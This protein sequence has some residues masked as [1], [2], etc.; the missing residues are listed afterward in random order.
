MWKIYGTARQAT[1]DNIIQ[2]M[3]F[4]CWTTKATNTHSD[5]ITLIAF[6]RQQWLRERA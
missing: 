1:D 2:R 4:A 6:S 5:Y 3:R